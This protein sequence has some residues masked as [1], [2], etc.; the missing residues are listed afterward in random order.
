MVVILGN[1]LGKFELR[2]D[3]KMDLYRDLEATGMTE[4]LVVGCMLDGVE[5]GM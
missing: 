5:S 2:T 1:F 3:L 4:D